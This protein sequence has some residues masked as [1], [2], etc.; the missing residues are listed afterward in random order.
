[1]P[2]GVIA[3]GPCPDTDVPMV[4]RIA[5]GEATREE[6]VAWLERRTAPA[7]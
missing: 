4:E 1:V 6:I 5:V 7:G 2:L 3:V